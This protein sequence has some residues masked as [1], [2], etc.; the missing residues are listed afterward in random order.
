MDPNEKNNQAQPGQQ[1]FTID[2]W[3]E[4]IPEDI[5][6]DASLKDIKDITSLAKGYVNS[7]KLIGS[8]LSIPGEGDEAAWNTLYDKLG[9]P[10]TPDKYE[11]KRPEIPEGLAY[12]EDL[13]KQFLPVA[14]KIGLNGKQA[15]ALIA[16][17]TEMVKQEAEQ[18]KQG[19]K[20][21]EEALKKEWGNDYA[22]KVSIAQRIIKDYAGQE[23]VDF[24]EK[25]K[26]GN[27]PA[28][29]K[30][31]HEIGSTLVEDGAAPK[32]G[33]NG[34][35]ISAEGAQ[36][37]INTLLA[38]PQF[39]SKYFNNRMPGHKEAVAEIFQLRQIVAGEG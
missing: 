24:L 39:T 4:T 27:N 17:Q 2:K 9:R 1:A 26:L 33:G 38:D 30:F 28:F 34:N 20:T 12:N 31:I 8:K 19:M 23:V 35:G 6:S 29:I 15:N 5:R 36:Q 18:Y 13:E 3:R 21:A 16:W 32:G 14:H 37:K 22:N 10:V 25:T 7:Q 11:V